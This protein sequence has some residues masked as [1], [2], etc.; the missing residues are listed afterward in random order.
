MARPRSEAGSGVDHLAVDHHV[1]RG[2]VFEAGND[3]QQ[4]RLATTRGPDEHDEF[5]AVNVEVDAMDHL[6]IAI[7][8]F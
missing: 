3:A 6:D 8:L 2:H 4:G 7:G 5:A 1:T